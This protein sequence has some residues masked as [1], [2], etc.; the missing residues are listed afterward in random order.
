MKPNRLYL[1]GFIGI[2]SGRGRH[3]IEICFDKLIPAAAKLIALTG[4]NGAGKTTILDNMQPYRIMPSHCATLSVGGF[5]YW[6]HIFGVSAKKELDW[7]HEGFKYRSTLT[8][9][10]P[11]KTPKADAYLFKWDQVK[12][13]WLPLTLPD[14]TLSDGKTATYDRC[15]EAILGS[16]ES[17]FTSIFAAQGRRALSAYSPSEIKALLAS[18][19]NLGNLRE[20]AAKANS[21]GRML[22]QDLDQLQ[23]VLAQARG[24]ATSIEQVNLEIAGFDQA[25]VGRAEVEQA[26]QVKIDDARKALA[27]LEAKRDALAQDEEQRTFL[28]QQ[29]RAV[30][31]ELE[32]AQQ[33]AEG[34]WRKDMQVITQNRHRATTELAKEKSKQAGVLAEIDRL[35]TIIGRSAEIK[36][37]SAAVPAL[38][39]NIL[40]IDSDIEANQ[41]KIDALRP[42]RQQLSQDTAKAEGIAT[43]GK[44]KARF[45][46]TLQQTAEL[47]TQVPCHS[48]DIQK[49][50]PL[51]KNANAAQ[52]KIR[53]EEEDV[54]KTR[55]EYREIKQRID[56][57]TK[58]VDE[59]AVFE[60]QAKTLAATRREKAK[61]LEKATQAAAEAPLLADAQRRLPELEQSVQSFNQ[62]QIAYDQSMRDMEAAEREHE[63]HRKTAIESATTT[64]TRKTAELRE[65]L[66]KLAAP[67]TE[68]ELVNAR[69]NVQAAIHGL[70]TERVR[71]KAYQEQ[72]NDLAVK[73]AGLKAV[74]AST[75]EKTREAENIGN[76]IAM[77]KRIEHGC[78]N[79]GLIALS[80]DDAGPEITAYCNELL[81]ECYGPRFSIQLDTQK[82]TQAGNMRE[83]F[84][85][86]VFDAQDGDEKSLTMMSP[87]ERVW[88]NECLARAIALY[89][90]ASSGKRYQTL[91]TD[92]TD[93]PLD[94]DRKRRFVDMKRA[95]LKQGGYDMEVFISHSREVQ[96][97]ADFEIDVSLL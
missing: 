95:V 28:T 83:T 91:F 23:D 36:A 68:A 56:A 97:M 69:T 19:L 22:K 43:A 64:A 25:L 18:V 86:R 93:G 34:Q 26:E 57:N 45:I 55:Q 9:K 72:R 51:L 81:T 13:E 60:Q 5:S 8:F 14:G 15:V 30:Q 37:A 53:P 41:A 6:D 48:M 78:G 89:G 54:Q 85:V 1:E 3:A 87:G 2:R 80:I 27:L 71:T 10:N 32:E 96:E 62:M 29:I 65:R 40:Q 77:W 82:A 47:I 66:A 35:K 90:A 76:E 39:E 73:L 44:E 52:A 59:G 49:T 17:F 24:A 4:P 50:C 33:R 79:N 58:L 74:L 92:E 63:A 16:P 42:V 12:G 88:I 75:E 31:T 61:L 20:L 94:A 38:R 11:G 70:T 7:E 84:D 46:I 21:V 67:V